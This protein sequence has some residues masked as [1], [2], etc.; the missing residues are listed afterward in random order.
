MSYSNFMP[1]AFGSDTG[2]ATCLFQM[3]ME[4]LP[5]SSI[6]YPFPDGFPHFISSWFGYKPPWATS[7]LLTRVIYLTLWPIFIPETFNCTNIF[8][9]IY[10]ASLITHKQ[11]YN[12]CSIILVTSSY[13]C[14]CGHRHRNSSTCGQE[15]L[16]EVIHSK[17]IHGLANISDKQSMFFYWSEIFFP[18]CR[19]LTVYYQF[20]PLWVMTCYIGDPPCSSNHSSDGTGEE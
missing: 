3:L 1:N 12:I 17:M 5:A 20:R 10:F 18:L 2:T 15:K 7:K 19:G 9:W 11:T 16:L 4:F 13:V 8:F 6:I 14:F